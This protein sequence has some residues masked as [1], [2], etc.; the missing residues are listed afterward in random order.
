MYKPYDFD[1]NKKY[2]I[3][4]Y[5]YQVLRPS[6]LEVL[7]DKPDRPA[8]FGFIVVTLG[9]RGGNPDPF[10]NGTPTTGRRSA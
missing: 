9:N 8:Q 10:P 1:P 2:P 7:L 4:A 6:R 5:V 3:V